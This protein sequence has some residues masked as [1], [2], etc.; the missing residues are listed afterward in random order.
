MSS[1]SATKI[2]ASS[3]RG[4]P[5]IVL[6]RKDNYDAAR[7]DVL[8]KFPH[9]KKYFD[10]KTKENNNSVGDSSDDDDDDMQ[11]QLDEQIDLWVEEKFNQL[12]SADLALYEKKQEQSKIDEWKRL[13]EQ[14][15]L[16]ENE[17]SKKKVA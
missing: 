17:E 15:R 8:A 9:F 4:T 13:R 2:E 16:I 6:F 11:E 5:G 10:S 1:S 7:A 14:G 3:I 12:S